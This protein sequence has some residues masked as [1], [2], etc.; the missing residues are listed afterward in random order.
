MTE[1]RK[2]SGVGVRA[3]LIGLAVGT[4]VLALLLACSSFVYYD[5]SSFAT[6]KQSTLSVL[7]SSVAQSAF[8]P[9]AFQDGESAGVILKVL[10]AEP[11]AR[12]GAI[13]AADG[14]RLS[15]WG[16]QGAEKTLPVKWNKKQAEHGYT[17]SL[18]VLTQP[19][20]KPEQEVGT[21]Q[22]VFSN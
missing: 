16:R 6:A 18:L 15:A 17:R 22:V 13:Y 19:N 11:S 14:S 12:A 2:R 20:R 5:R 9:T 1:R 4:S 8:G 7:V 21:M 3:K 10:D